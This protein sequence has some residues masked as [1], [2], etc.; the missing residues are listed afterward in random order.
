VTFRPIDMSY[1]TASCV[2]P[3]WL[4]F[5]SLGSILLS[6]I[7]LLLKLLG[8]LLIDKR[9]CGEAFFKLERMEEGSV[10]VVGK[11]IVDF[12][13][14]YHTSV[15]RLNPGA[16]ACAHGS[17]CVVFV[18]TEMSTSLIQKVFPTVSFDNTAAPC[19]PVYVHLA[20]LG[21]AT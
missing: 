12:L 13:V 21:Y 18:R 4:N 11:S 17:H 6:I 8:F 9:E 16:S 1:C 19:R 5:G 3:E 20:L 15:G 2:R 7:H 14:P 10:L